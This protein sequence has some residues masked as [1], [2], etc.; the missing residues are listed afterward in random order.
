LG[1]TPI[2]STPILAGGGFWDFG[3]RK[4]GPP[5]SG[6]GPGTDR[7]RTEG[8][9]KKIL[10]KKFFVKNIFGVRKKKK[11]IKKKFL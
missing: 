1:Q 5:D 4:I 2:S 3:G 7:V 11:F 6:I 9:E 10:K 8:D